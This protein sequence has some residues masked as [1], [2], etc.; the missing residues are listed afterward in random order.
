MGNFRLI[1][2]FAAGTT[3]LALLTACGGSDVQE[4]ANGAP[5][6]AAQSAGG[7][8]SDA[9]GAA[10]GTDATAAAAGAPGTTTTTASTGTGAAAGAATDTAKNS[11]GGAA[12]QNS[13]ATTSAGKNRTATA[14]SAS[15]VEQL[16]ASHPIFGG[17]AA[18]K[19]ATLSEIPLGN[20]ST[21]SGVLGELLSPVRPALETFVASQNACGGLNGHRIKLYFEDD[22]SD[23]STAIAKVQGMIQQQK[24]LAF[25]GN[26]QPLSIDAV[27]PTINKYKIPM[28]GGDLVSNTWFT[29]PLL[30][31]QGSS[32]GAVAYGYLL[33]ATSYFKKTNVGDIWCIEV[34]RACEQIDRA[35]K[36]LAPTVG[37][38][39]KKS[40]QASI[41]A[42]S[43]VQQC[44]DFKGA[45]VD[46]LALITDAATMTRMARSCE[47]VGYYPNLMPTPLGVGN[48]K[49]F[50]NGNKW[51]GNSYVAMNYFP[52][53]ATD[54]PA[55]KYFHASIQKYNPGF[56]MGGAA[57]TGW[58]SGA[59]LVAAAA[60]LSPTNPTTA[61]LLNGL[62]QFKG[63]KWTEL[64]GL[65]GPRT[66][67]ENGMP[68]VPYCLFAGISNADN[69]GWAKSVSKAVCTDKL[70]PS[71]PQ[72]SK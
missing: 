24:V 29:N 33:G 43:Y 64:G 27:L 41:T 70:A 47:Q 52:W 6:A 25:V 72:N 36:E 22:Q 8:G 15:A 26:I 42:P 34:P 14:G 62:W 21:F 67:V 49:Q 39:V 17:S 45:K 3:A 2:A 20:V 13:T 46:A 56:D 65:N 44:L 5:D 4:A 53:F 37:A 68:K 35:F 59:M 11:T 55:Q 71:D 10:A 54:T 57:S 1:R 50:L 32:P 38:T 51:L 23:P 28:I 66:F 60:Q 31:P 40:I 18:C 7:A 9:P 63:Q 16:V 48:E 30:F 61:D 58:S 12:K 69:T 19:P